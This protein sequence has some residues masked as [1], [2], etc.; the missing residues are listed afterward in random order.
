MADNITNLKNWFDQLTR[1]EQE[2]VLEF[3]YGNALVKRTGYTGPPP[4]WATKGLY[5][6]D[7]P[8]ST[9]ACPTCGRPY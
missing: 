4:G 1:S 6:G 5:C 2:R 3:L 8:S 9:S 7:A